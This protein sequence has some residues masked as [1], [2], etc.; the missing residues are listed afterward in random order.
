MGTEFL[1]PKKENKMNNKKSDGS[2]GDRS[3][4][5]NTGSEMNNPKKNEKGIFYWLYMLF[6][7][8]NIY[9]ENFIKN[10]YT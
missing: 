6:I 3:K 8:H 9:Y 1:A 4:P 2:T 10:Q 7:L 5:R